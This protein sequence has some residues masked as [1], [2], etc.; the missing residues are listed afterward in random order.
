M[1]G[2]GSVRRSPSGKILTGIRGDPEIRYH[3]KDTR[4]FDQSMRYLMDRDKV[5][6]YKRDLDRQLE[7]NKKWR[8]RLG[9]G[10]IKEITRKGFIENG[11]NSD[12]SKLNPL[13]PG[14]HHHNHR[15]QFNHSEGISGNN[16]NGS[17]LAPLMRKFNSL[18][19]LNGLSSTDVTRPYVQ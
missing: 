4:G 5:L 10:A 3:Q 11:D 1:G 9:S 17:E 14:G 13:P 15:Y 2:A 8:N 12:G 19:K 6:E 16:K 18:P 7:E